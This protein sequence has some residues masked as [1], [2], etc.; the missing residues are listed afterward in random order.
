MVYEYII[1]MVNRGLRIDGRKFFEY[2]P[3]QIRVNV[4]KNAEGSALVSLGETKVLAGVKMDI[5]EPF[6]DRPDEGVLIVNAEFAP[7]ASPMFEPGPP[8]EDAIE[9]ARVVDRGIRE[10]N[11]IDLKSLCIEAGSKVWG[12]F[13]DIYILNH[14]GNLIDA[15]ALAAIV[16]LLTARFPIVEGDKVVYG[17]WCEKKLKVNKIPVCCTFVKIG[18]HFLLDP[19]LREES[20][21]EAG[22][23]VIVTD[24]KTNALQKR[25]EIGGLKFAEVMKCIEIALEK[26]KELKQ[27]VE[28]AV[29]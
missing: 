24:E 20:A 13:V 23:S 4:S 1:D 21:L 3:I 11:A 26:G 18:N 22:L 12:I 19:N 6:E 17:K 9:L 8:N 29:S 5:V 15:S 25:G 2:R 7:L 28:R 16:S 10:S 27:M 14:D